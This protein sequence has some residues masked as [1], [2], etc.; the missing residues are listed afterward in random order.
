ML[1]KD[2]NSIIRKSFAEQ[3]SYAF[4][5]QDSGQYINGTVTHQKNP[6]DGFAYYDRHFV[7]WESKFLPKPMSLN[8]QRLEDH[9]LEALLNTRDNL[10][11]SYALF[12][13]GVK[14][15]A[16]ETR[17]YAF[18]DLDEIAKRRET[19]DNILKKEFEALDN[20]VV[21]KKG[22]VDVAEMLS[23]AGLVSTTVS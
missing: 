18:S 5:I 22:V 19:H 1:E 20:Y 8:L 2:L 6:Y 23:K 15:T 10:D 4:K 21:V 17:V 14:W 7:A 11:C 13:V 9:Q 3:G 16:R 12:L